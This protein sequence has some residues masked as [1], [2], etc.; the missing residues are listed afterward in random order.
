MASITYLG[1]KP[2]TNF[3]IPVPENFFPVRTEE[4]FNTAIR[5]IEGESMPDVLYF[6]AKWLIHRS[7]SGRVS[8]ENSR[9]A[10][11]VRLFQED[12]AGKLKELNITF[13]EF[14]P[15]I[16][17]P[18]TTVYFYCNIFTI[19]VFEEYKSSSYEKLVSSIDAHPSKVVQTLLKSFLVK[20]Y[21]RQK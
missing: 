14:E 9:R 3:E 16:Q 21:R 20:I 6:T 5:K 19:G 15:L 13:G 1:S 11:V 7:Y 8:S 4:E 18:Y 17:K 12:L 2:P 10:N